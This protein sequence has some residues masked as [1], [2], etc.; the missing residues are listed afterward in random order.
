MKHMIRSGETGK[1]VHTAEGMGE[2]IRWFA[3]NDPNYEN[4]RCV[5]YGVLS[6]YRD[7]VMNSYQ[8]TKGAFA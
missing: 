5:G 2:C 3:D 4:H 1:I 6:E 7:I 8:N